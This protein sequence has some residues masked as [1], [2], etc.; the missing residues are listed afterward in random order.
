MVVVGIDISP[1]LYRLTENITSSDVF[2][3]NNPKVPLLSA[4]NMITHNIGL[5]IHKH[6]L[7]LFL[8][9]DNVSHPLKEATQTKHRND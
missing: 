6:G 1:L 8:C 4:Y 2:D 7:N 9:F 3:I 5:L